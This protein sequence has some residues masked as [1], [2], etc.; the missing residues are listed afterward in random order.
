MVLFFVKTAWFQKKKKSKSRQ[1]P[2]NILMEDKLMNFTW[3]LIQHEVQVFTIAHNCRMMSTPV[4]IHAL[5]KFGNHK[6]LMK[7]NCSEEKNHRESLQTCHLNPSRVLYALSSFGVEIGCLCLCILKALYSLCPASS[8]L[9]L[10]SSVG[11]FDGGI[12]KNK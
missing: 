4:D 10:P 6:I 5:G 7:C 1:L 2:Y 11:C 12:W 3:A 8:A 9:V